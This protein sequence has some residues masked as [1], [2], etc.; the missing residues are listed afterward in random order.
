MTKR[1]QKYPQPVPLA[2]E[3]Q[4]IKIRHQLKPKNYSQELALESLREQPMT[5]LSGPAGSGK[6]FLITLVAIEKLINHEVDKVVVTRPVVEAGENLGFLPGTLE[7]KLDPYLLPLV[8]AIEDHIGPVMTKKLF[9]SGK[10]EV[11]P[12]AFMRGRTFNNCLPADHKVLLSSGEWIR[13][14]ALLDEFNA[15]KYLEVVT[16]NIE[17]NQLENKHVK[18][19]FKQKNQHKKLVKLTLKNGAEIRAAPDHK[20]FPQRGYVAINN[21]TLEDQIIGT[22]EAQN[23]FNGSKTK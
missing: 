21:L 4:A 19:A 12:L 20:L 7:E 14:D 23:F 22:D 6:T 9:E 11:A 2:S 16:F 5:I 1:R 17:S 8:D 18:Y 10:I 3:G 15:E 13:M